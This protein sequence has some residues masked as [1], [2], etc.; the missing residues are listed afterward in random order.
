[1]R[2]ILFFVTPYVSIGYLIC[3][4]YITFG[5]KTPSGDPEGSGKACGSMQ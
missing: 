5:V 4:I 1:M 2:F 3:N